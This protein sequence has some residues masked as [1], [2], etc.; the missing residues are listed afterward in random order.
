MKGKWEEQVSWD[1]DEI[2]KMR[3]EGI[4]KTKGMCI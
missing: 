3:V 4:F 1:K 2:K